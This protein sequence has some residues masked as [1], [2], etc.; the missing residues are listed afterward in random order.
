MREF[1]GISDKNDNPIFVGDKVKKTWG[2]WA[3]SGYDVREH[4]ITKYAELNRVEYR[5]DDLANI[6]SGECVEIVDI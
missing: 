1:T 6:W 2:W 5:L 3:N 4:T